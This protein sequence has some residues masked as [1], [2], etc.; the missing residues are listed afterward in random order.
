MLDL[1]FPPVVVP[2]PTRVVQRADI[3]P[4]RVPVPA[5][6]QPKKPRRTPEQVLA[7]AR[8]RAAAKREQKRQ[9]RI[10]DGTYRSQSEQ[11]RLA[12][13]ASAEARRLPPDVA[14]ERRRQRNR[15]GNERRR[16]QDRN[17]SGRLER[18]RLDAHS[19]NAQEAA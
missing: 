11:M 15:L 4:R 6:L 16:Q 9:A 3:D 1:F 8:A 10:A 19:S 2:K 5:A 18:G 13:I 7:D 17:L 12:R 14:L